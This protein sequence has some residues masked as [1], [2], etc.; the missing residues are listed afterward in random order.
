ME[1]NN[2]EV[3]VT[4]HNQKNPVRENKPNSIGDSLSDNKKEGYPYPEEKDKQANNQPE[5][6]EKTNDTSKTDNKA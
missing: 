1:H 2:R 3:D 4:K 6:I 5:F